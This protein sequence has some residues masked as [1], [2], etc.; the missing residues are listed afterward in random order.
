MGAFVLLH[1]PL[2]RGN[3]VGSPSRII[4]VFFFFARELHS[5]KDC[6][7]NI[8]LCLRYSSFTSVSHQGTK[9]TMVRSYI[10]LLGVP[11]GT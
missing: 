10:I 9:G 8:L 1:P 5:T 6:V 4:D 2:S 7:E 3:L 11:K